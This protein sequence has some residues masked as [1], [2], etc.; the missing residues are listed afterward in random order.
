MTDANKDPS[1]PPAHL[2]GGTGTGP[3]GGEPVQPT[4]PARDPAA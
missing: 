1:H 4:T 3:A 2:P